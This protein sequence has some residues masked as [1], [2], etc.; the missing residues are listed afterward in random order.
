MKFPLFYYLLWFSCQNC[1]TLTFF[2]AFKSI[3]FPTQSDFTG[4]WGRWSRSL[5]P[6]A[7]KALR[8]VASSRSF[9]SWE[10]SWHISLYV[11]YRWITNY[12]NSRPFFIGEIVY[13]KHFKR[14]D[15][16]RQKQET[17]EQMM[18]VSFVSFLLSRSK[19]CALLVI[20]ISSISSSLSSIS[21]RLGCS[22][23]TSTS[24]SSPTS[25]PRPSLASWDPQTKS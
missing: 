11:E 17:N 18:T 5:E 12:R 1:L 22:A 13:P 15:Y 21:T 23:S 7:Q 3:F 6:R 25:S 9:S 19:A 8:K 20:S 4:R 10:N 2:S 16:E 24:T 14:K